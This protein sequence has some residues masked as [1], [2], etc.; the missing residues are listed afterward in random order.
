MHSRMCTLDSPIEIV[1]LL[2][3]ASVHLGTL[4][5]AIG[6]HNHDSRPGKPF[7]MLVRMRTD[8]SQ[9]CQAFLTI[10]F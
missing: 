2:S 6:L 1:W 4:P 5:A 3:H 8:C 10:Y 7:G 9:A